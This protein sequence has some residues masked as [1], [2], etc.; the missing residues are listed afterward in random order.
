MTTHLAH[1]IELE[2]AFYEIDPMDVVW[3]GHYA[4]FLEKAR[5]A[6]LAK[7][8]IGYRELRELGYVFPI[9]ELFI[10]YAQPLRLGQRVRVSARIVEWESRLRINYEIHDCASGRRLTKAHTVQV[11]VDVRTG[12]LCYICPKELW[13]GLGV[14]PP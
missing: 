14:A 9:I 13:E 12:E 5:G 10:R 11:A 3:H 8:N 7:L 1:E 6:L 2:P 4:K